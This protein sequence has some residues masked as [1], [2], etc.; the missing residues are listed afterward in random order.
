[1]V[2][3]GSPGSEHGVGQAPG[4]QRSTGQADARPDVTKMSNKIGGIDYQWIGL[5]KKT[6]TF[7][8]FMKKSMVS[9]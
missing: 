6:R 5:R 1:M 4:G 9:G 3:G 7:I 8:H 2:P